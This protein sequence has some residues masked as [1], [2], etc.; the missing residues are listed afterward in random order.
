MPTS[1]AALCDDFYINQRLGLKMDLP[2]RRDSALSMF[3]RLRRDHPTLSRFRKQGQEL[4]LES[5]ETAGAE[6]AA[7]VAVA[8]PSSRTQSWVA[9]RKTSVRSGSV[10]PDSLAEGYSLHR[11]V[12]ETAPYFLDI[13]ALDIEFVELL[14]GFDLHFAGNHDE[15]VFQALMADS[16][17][18][19]LARVPGALPIDCQPSFGIALNGPCTIHAHME[20]KTRS[21]PRGAPRAGEFNVEP[22]SVYVTLRKYGPCLDVANLPEVLDELADHA[23][24]IADERAVPGLIT[25]IRAA[26]ASGNV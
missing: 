1:Y 20:V 23:E 5:T 12:L 18:A 3:D 4:S 26:I 14:I 10:N 25:P 22:I 6:Q 7:S 9:L 11:L 2:L 19:A 17:L 8:P 13:S 16:P 24:T 21:S 15:V